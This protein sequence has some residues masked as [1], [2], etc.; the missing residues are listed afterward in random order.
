VNDWAYAFGAVLIGAVVLGSM[1]TMAAR[2]ME[3]L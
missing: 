3:E 1:V 2:F